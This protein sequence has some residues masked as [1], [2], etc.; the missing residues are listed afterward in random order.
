MLY[1]PY[2]EKASSNM[3]SLK[4]KSN[5]PKNDADTFKGR[6]FKDA[7]ET[8]TYRIAEID[9]KTG[10]QV[11]DPKTGPKWKE[12][13]NLCKIK[14]TPAAML[15]VDF[16]THSPPVANPSTVMSF[17]AF[18]GLV[19]A[20]RPGLFCIATD[21]RRLGS[22]ETEDSTLPDPPVGRAAPVP[23]DGDGATLKIPDQ[24]RIAGVPKT[25]ANNK[26]DSLLAPALIVALLTYRRS[27]RNQ[28]AHLAGH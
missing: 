21:R 26:R 10:K 7:T 16:F 18:L 1:V 17:E 5:H 3:T 2:W 25:T 11:V 12:Y 22:N 28:Y 15:G 24:L 9:P 4:A 23:G 13:G 27:V 19:D 8:L 20:T 6:L 14:Y